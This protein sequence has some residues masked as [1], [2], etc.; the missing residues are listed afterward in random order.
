MPRILLVDDSA[1]ERAIYRRLLG[2]GWTFLEASSGEEALELHRRHRPDLV[3]LDYH[4]PD[5]LGVDL[6][7]AVGPAIMLTGQGNEAVAVEA[8][9]RGALDYLSKSVLNRDSL[10]R[11]VRTALD[12]VAM[13]RRLRMHRALTE[14]ALLLAQAD[15]VR[16]VIPPLLREIGQA[17]E[18]DEAVWWDTGTEPGFRWPEGGAPLVN[19]GELA[20]KVWAEHRPLWE[21]ASLALPVQL[22]GRVTAVI[23]C[24]RICEREPDPSLVPLAAAIGSQIGQ[25]IER[26]RAEA[27]LR[28]SNE[29]LQ[30]FAYVASHDLQEPLRMVAGFTQLLARRTQGRLDE[31]TSEYMTYILDGVSRMRELINALLEYSRVGTRGQQFE[32]VSLDSIFQQSL[33]N[34]QASVEESGAEVISGPLP[35]VTGDRIQ[36]TQL[37]QNLIGNALKFRGVEPPH[38]RAA[39]E[40][41]DGEWVLS[42]SDNGIG[43]APEF[44]DRIFVIFQRLH[45]PGEYPGTG[46]G[47]AIAKK[48]V[49]RHGGRIWVESEP[50]RGA[51]FRFTLPD[52]LSDKCG[53]G[54]AG[55]PDGGG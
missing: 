2:P 31:K 17:M 11:A 45:G 7:D 47:L 28:R 54:A 49:E 6:V 41:R 3:L 42:I 34:L 40:R 46:M 12:R 24:R 50:G 18:W 29:D 19:S 30:Q 38:V 1:E 16:D 9:K 14:I 43:V 15:S 13:Q 23:E 51:A 32:P 33:R 53:Y 55:Y 44:A 52:A 5:S 37:L 21:A 26:R 22:A 27:E 36:L 10:Q 8:M 4:L 39:A 25:F 20:A 35:E 48:I